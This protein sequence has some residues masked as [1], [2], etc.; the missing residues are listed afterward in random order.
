MSP[1]QKNPNHH[2]ATN[3]RKFCKKF[4]VYCHPRRSNTAAP[5]DQILV[6][7]GTPI[8][9]SVARA[10]LGAIGAGRGR[11]CRIPIVPLFIL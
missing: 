2:L 5:T 6:L 1:A 4:V 8:A 3:H 7:C 9:P 11:G 10:T